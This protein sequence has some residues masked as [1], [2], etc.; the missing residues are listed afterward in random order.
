MP[1]RKEKAVR[2][3]V[4]QLRPGVPLS[5]VVPQE[6]RRRH[7]TR[8]SELDRLGEAVLA[9]RPLDETESR[10]MFSILS[11]GLRPLI[12]VLDDL[13]A[14]T[15]HPLWP[16]LTEAP[17]QSVIAQVAKATGRIEFSGGAEFRNAGSGFLVGDR[18][19]ATNRHVAEIFCVEF[20]GFGSFLR[21]QFSARINFCREAR[22]W[23]TNPT[24]TFL[25]TRV[26][27]MHPWFDLALLRLGDAPD[28]IAPL[29]LAT[30]NAA[31]GQKCCVIGYPS[32]NPDEDTDI[33]REAITEFDAKHL[34]PGLIDTITSLTLRGRHMRALGHDS[35]T[36][37]GNSGAPV[38]DLATGT[39]LGLHFN[40]NVEGLNWA[41]PA[42]D[43][44]ADARIIDAGVA[45]DGVPVPSDGPWATAW[46][47]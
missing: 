5:R 25:I 44:A 15:G 31:E 20:A 10:I 23:D 36:L 18:L 29:K 2:K 9:G 26:E 17:V 13:P 4:T 43:I 27:M 45:F 11:P 39:V 22:R 3:L 47:A 33:Q 19:I 40:G 38:A 16:E 42:A 14:D 28:D 21:P 8:A 35:S 41:I 34:S 30:G 37:T 32:F 12:E 7:L 24:R 6:I 46:A 1:N